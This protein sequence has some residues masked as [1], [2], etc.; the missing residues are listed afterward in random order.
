MMLARSNRRSGAVLAVVMVTLFLILI[1]GTALI[2]MGSLQRRQTMVAE[3]RAQS[4]WLAES[5]LER[6]KVKIQASE[7]Y[8]GETWTIKSADLG[9]RGDGVVVITVT[10]ASGREDRLKVQVQANYPVGVTLDSQ[11]SKSVKMG[12]KSV[13]KGEKSP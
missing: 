3:R 4:E 5:G 8:Q 11:T 13:T 12:R 7:G 9:G 2:R 10:P 1:V 6:A